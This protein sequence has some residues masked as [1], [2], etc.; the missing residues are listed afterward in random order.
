MACG[1]A[2]WYGLAI[3]CAA[4]VDAVALAIED[5]HGR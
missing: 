1:L 5:D 3:A 4:T 2:A